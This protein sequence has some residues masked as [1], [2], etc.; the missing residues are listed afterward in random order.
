MMEASLDQNR[1]V[2]RWQYE[3]PVSQQMTHQLLEVVSHCNITNNK[4]KSFSVPLLVVSE[5]I[6]SF[7]NQITCNESRAYNSCPYIEIYLLI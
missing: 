5:N 4:K 2:C 1:E 3:T 6:T 7:T